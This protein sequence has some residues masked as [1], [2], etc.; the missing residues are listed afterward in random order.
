MRLFIAF[1]V[2]EDVS[3]ILRSVQSKIR[4]SGSCSKTN[5]FH[6]TL[7]FLGEVEDSKLDALKRALGSVSFK[8]FEAHL[9]GIGVFPSKHDARVVWVGVEPKDIIKAVQRQVDDVTIPLG[10]AMDKE[11]NPHLTLA[12]IKFID[13]K[14]SFENMFDNLEVPGGSFEIDSFKLIKSTLTSQGPVYEVLK[15][16]RATR[17]WCENKV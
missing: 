3:E 14:K 5:D 12:R 8:K 6:M 9:A 2:S 16:F 17:G 11:F 4:F 10:F 13:D 15:V 7:K 1:D